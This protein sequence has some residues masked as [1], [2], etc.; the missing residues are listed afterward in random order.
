MTQGGGPPPTRRARL[1]ALVLVLTSSAMPAAGC[2]GGDDTTTPA[3]EPLTQDE[4][5]TEVRDSIG[6]VADESQQ[7]IAQATEARRIQDLAK[8]LGQAQETY[9]DAA[10]QLESL[11]PPEEVA[12]LHGELVRAQED[13]ADAARSAQR[14]A[15]KGNRQGLEKF[16]RAGDR[17]RDRAEE[18]SQEFSERG[19]EF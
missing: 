4:Y 11:E 3:D 6:P 10:D 12:K 13:I 7:L 17:Y 16:R 2:G 19:F 14:A 15:R 8:P 18:L 9:Q 1:V 5:V